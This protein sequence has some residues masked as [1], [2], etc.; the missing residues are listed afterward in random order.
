[1][2][3]LDVYDPATC[4]AT[5]VCGPGVDES[6]AQFASALEALRE[7]GV[8]VSRYNLSQQPGAFASHPTVS[9]AL[10]QQGVDCLRS[11]PQPWQVSQPDGARTG[12][13]ADQASY[14]TWGARGGRLLLR[15]SPRRRIGQQ[16]V[17]LKAMGPRPLAGLIHGRRIPALDEH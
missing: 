1:M 9:A 14:S 12:Q 8:A 7:R 15:L 10:K 3:Q 13:A 5:G 16:Q 11:G 6:L 2:N 4:C 17:L